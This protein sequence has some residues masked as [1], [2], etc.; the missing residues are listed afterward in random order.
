MY[1]WYASGW[2]PPPLPSTSIEGS[3]SP[4]PLNISLVS[5]LILPNREPMRCKNGFGRGPPST[6]RSLSRD[7]GARGFGA[8][9]IGAAS[10]RVKSAASSPFR[11]LAAP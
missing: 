3:T 11:R 9:S 8:A 2:S 4:P 6:S 1:P 7:A 10:V 5:R